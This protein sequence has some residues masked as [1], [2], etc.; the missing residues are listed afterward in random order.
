M[1]I[2]GVLAL[3]LTVLSGVSACANKPVEQ[4][5]QTQ[6]GSGGGGGGGSSGGGGSGGGGGGR[7]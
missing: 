7:Y 4:S 2:L 1:K 3:L 6:S 5:A